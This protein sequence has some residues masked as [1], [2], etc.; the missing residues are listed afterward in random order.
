MRNFLQ[1]MLMG[2][3]VVSLLTLSNMVFEYRP[4]FYTATGVVIFDLLMAFVLIKLAY[5]KLSEGLSE[6]KYT[7]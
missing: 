1:N 4:S 3:I 5:K 6:W 7:K 2:L